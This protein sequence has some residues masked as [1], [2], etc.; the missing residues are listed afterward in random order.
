MI[1]YSELKIRNW[2]V[3]LFVVG[4]VLEEHTTTESHRHSVLYWLVWWAPWEVRDWVCPPEARVS[5]E[6]NRERNS[7]FCSLFVLLW[8]P[9]TLSLSPSCPLSA[10]HPSHRKRLIILTD[11][12]LMFRRM[13]ILKSRVVFLHTSFWHLSSWDGE[14]L[15]SGPTEDLRPTPLPSSLTVQSGDIAVH[16]QQTPCAP[17]LRLL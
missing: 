5:D 8:C 17:H 1:T 11:Q 2:P 9:S 3:S 6:V 13:Q 4:L 15:S 16:V 10:S 12:Y 7:P 14:V